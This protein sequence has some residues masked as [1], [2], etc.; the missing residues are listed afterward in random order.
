MRFYLMQA[1]GPEFVPGIDRETS[2]EREPDQTGNRPAKTTRKDEDKPILQHNAPTFTP[3]Q[4]RAFIWFAIALVVGIL[5]WLLSPVLTPF[6]LGAIL[7]Y[8]LHPGV[9]WLTRRR[10]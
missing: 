6:L 2:L 4:R 7:A 8:I 5:L 9:G 10:V 3:Y 1:R